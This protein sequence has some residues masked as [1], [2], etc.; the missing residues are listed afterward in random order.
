[1]GHSNDGVM[2]VLVHLWLLSSL[3]RHIRIFL[4]VRDVRNWILFSPSLCVPPIAHVEKYVWLTH[5]I[6][7]LVCS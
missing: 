4:Q 7:I 1:M 3:A 2:H 6:A 5:A